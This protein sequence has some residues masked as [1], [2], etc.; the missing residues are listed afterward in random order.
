MKAY[1]LKYNK[2]LQGNMDPGVL[3][4]DKIKEE[5]AKI[6]KDWSDVPFVFNL[7][8]GMWPCHDPENVE[9]LVKEVHS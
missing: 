9:I 4:G 8:H 1:A 6:L 2:V 5:V 7:G 3:L